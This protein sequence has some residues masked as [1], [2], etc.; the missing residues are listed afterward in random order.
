M[1]ISMRVEEKENKDENIKESYF[2]VCSQINKRRG[3]RTRL[4][5]T[6][7]DNSFYQLQVAM[8]AQLRLA[9]LVKI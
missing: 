6:K 5:I 1:T 3:V 7:G 4:N 9:C 8:F 2:S